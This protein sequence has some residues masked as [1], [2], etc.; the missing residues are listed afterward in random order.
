MCA[1]RE[2]DAG[3]RKQV[4]KGKSAIYSGMTLRNYKGVLLNVDSYA[5]STCPFEKTYT[6][7]RL[8]GNRVSGN[9][10]ELRAQINYAGSFYF[11][12]ITLSE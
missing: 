12:L 7:L 10:S 4:R 1:E 5:V 2:E 3:E 8:K 9:T 11:V 6:S